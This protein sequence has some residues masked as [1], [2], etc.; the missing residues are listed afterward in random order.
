MNPILLKPTS[1]MGSQVVVQGKVWRNLRAREYYEHHEFLKRKVSESYENLSEQYEF[2]VV[3]GAGSIAEL[4]L[5]RTDLVNLGL[6]RRFNIPVLLVAD[7]DRGGV[8]GSLY[9]TISLLEPE[10]REL[11][12][13]F[14]VNRFRGDPSLF[15]S[16]V[17]LLEEKTGK[18]CLGVFPYRSEIELDQEDSVSLEHSVQDSGGSLDGP[19]VAIV[20]LP[21]VSNHTDVRSLVG[22]E[23]IERPN[24]KLFDV[25][26]L[27]GT[28]STMADLEWVKARGLD[29]WIKHQHARG[30]Q[31]VGICGGYQMMGMTIEDPWRVE[32]SV[33]RMDGLGLLPVQTQL[34]TEKVT[35]VVQAR[36][37]AGYV[38][39]AYEIHMGE[40]VLLHA[41]EAFATVDGAPEG[42]CMDRCLGTYLHGAF[43]HPQVLAEYIGI[44]AAPAVSR[45]QT[46]DDLADWFSANADRSLFERLFVSSL[47]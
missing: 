11:V 17:E 32:S 6:A 41:G 30:A 44:S 40:T 29:R 14:A 7:I 27:P 24:D 37:K 8:F 4:N 1:N 35:R 38:F 25:V 15:S 20:R 47:P 18:P 16:G 43:E 28:K 21:H 22:A 45:A 9:G 5:R 33:G 19:K 34:L 23:W 42:I 13:A 36:T 2:I 26:V 10:E 46:Y 31:V 39:S 12:R 3:E